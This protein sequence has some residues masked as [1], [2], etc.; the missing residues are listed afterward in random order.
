MY[1]LG[2]GSVKPAVLKCPDGSFMTNGRC[3]C[4]TL[5]NRTI[6]WYDNWSVKSNHD[7]ILE[8]CQQL[9]EAIA[10]AAVPSKTK[11]DLG[12]A[13]VTAFNAREISEAEL[14]ECYALSQEGE[15]YFR[16]AFEPAAPI[17]SRPT[18][19]HTTVELETPVKLPTPVGIPT[20]VVVPT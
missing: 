9:E 10:A 18:P 2:N 11:A 15:D 1:N 4:P 14:H 3:P 17:P 12:G 5:P 8:Q 13:C 16:F 6:K 19:Q 20:P 7:S